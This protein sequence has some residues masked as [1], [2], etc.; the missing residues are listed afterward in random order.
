MFVMEGMAEAVSSPHRVYPPS[1]APATW[2][3]SVSLRHIL[4]AP[5]ALHYSMR[6]LKGNWGAPVLLWASLGSC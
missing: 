2:S 5:L 6:E 1:L 3:S 4:L